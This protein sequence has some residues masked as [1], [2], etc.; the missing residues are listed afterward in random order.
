MNAHAIAYRDR[1]TTVA[2]VNN[3]A[4]EAHG[5]EDLTDVDSVQ[6]WQG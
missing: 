5:I 4:G 2:T 6:S 1:T 3:R